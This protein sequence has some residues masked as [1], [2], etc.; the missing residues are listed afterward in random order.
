[1]LCS[2][3]HVCRA[4]SPML[5]VFR[6]GGRIAS[7]RANTTLCT[8]KKSQLKAA[9]RAASSGEPRKVRIRS[10]DPFKLQW[11]KSLEAVFS[12]CNNRQVTNVSGFLCRWTKR[13]GMV[14]TRRTQ[15]RAV[16]QLTPRRPTTHSIITGRMIAAGVSAL[17]FSALTARCFLSTCCRHLTWLEA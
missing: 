2:D 9:H 3:N 15:S 4:D 16:T 7:T 17:C 14:A 1:M 5:L 8:W 6:G 11:N 10:A 13:L 12:V